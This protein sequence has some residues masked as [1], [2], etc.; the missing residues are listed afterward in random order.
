[1]YEGQTQIVYEAVPM[2]NMS[3]VSAEGMP[4]SVWVDEDGFIHVPGGEIL[5]RLT[6]VNC[7]VEQLGLNLTL[8]EGGQAMAAVYMRDEGNFYTYQLG[9][10]R[11]IWQWVLKSKAFLVYPYGQVEDIFISLRSVSAGQEL[12]CRLEGVE[13]N[14][15]MPF[16][17]SAPRAILVYLALLLLFV[18]SK[19]SGLERIGFWPEDMSGKQKKQR[20]A[21]VAMCIALF[22]GL[23]A[24][25]VLANPMCRQN[26]GLHHAQYQELAAALALGEPAVGAADER[27]TRVKDP[28]VTC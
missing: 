13:V 28:Y 4:E 12:V 18:F 1:M 7:D 26:L 15:Q 9:N 10:E 23:A 11:R 5:I 16:A 3:Q 8:P 14:G 17:F 19:K 27:L 2:E 20:L 6:G 24:L 21:A 22:A 25:A